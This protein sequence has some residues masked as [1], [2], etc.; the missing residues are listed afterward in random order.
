MATLRKKHRS[1]LG[2]LWRFL[3]KLVAV[4][5]ISTIGTTILYRWVNPPITPLMVIRLFEQKSEGKELKMKYDWVNIDSI[6]PYMWQGVIAGEDGY[7]LYHNGFDWDAI[8]NAKEYNKTHKIKRGAST[9]SQQTAKNVF[10]WPDRTWV[11][12]GL[13]VYFTFLIET[14]WSKER[15]M[16]VYLNVIEY[17]DGIYGVEEA[18]EE[19]FKTHANKLS[20]DQAALLV[21]SLPN[22]RKWNVKTGDPNL[23]S[24]KNIISRN[25][26]NIGPQKL[27]KHPYSEVRGKNK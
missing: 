26:L 3:L 17:G 13:E 6:S 16:E 20:F 7:F 24:R 9:I 25:M 21:A 10:L 8:E 19:Y 23:Y 1:F 4:F 11:R 18:S 22:P 5:F 15:I 14:F 12:K 2:R 27:E